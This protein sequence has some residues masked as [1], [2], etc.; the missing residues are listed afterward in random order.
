MPLLRILRLVDAVRRRNRPQ[1]GEEPALAL[2]RCGKST[3][4]SVHPE[5]TGLHP[6]LVE[7]Q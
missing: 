5:F 1:P 2:L 6:F 7:A 3:G 4:F